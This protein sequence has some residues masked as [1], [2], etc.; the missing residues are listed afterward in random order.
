M[1]MEPMEGKLDS[2]LFDLGHTDLFCIPEVTSVFCSSCD[3]VVGV[4]ERDPVIYALTEMDPE[5][6]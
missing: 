4:C 3:I 6:P 2:F 1:V 5:M